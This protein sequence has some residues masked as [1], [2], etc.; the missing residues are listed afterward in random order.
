[1]TILNKP[2]W[3]KSA[4][5]GERSVAILTGVG[6][7]RSGRRQAEVQ[8][9]VMPTGYKIAWRWGDN[10][11]WLSVDGVASSIDEAKKL[12]ESEGFHR[13]ADII[14]GATRDGNKITP[15]KSVAW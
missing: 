11:P 5:G 14:N 12:V 6:P 8:V 2:V 10:T 9:G 13:I 7:M 4:N 1:M 15:L 3:K